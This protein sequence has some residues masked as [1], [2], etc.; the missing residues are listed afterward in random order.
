MGFVSG[1]EFIVAIDEAKKV[2]ADIL[3]GDR[4]VKVHAISLAGGGSSSSSGYHADA[5]HM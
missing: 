1:Q 3:L 5:H 4:D 2:G